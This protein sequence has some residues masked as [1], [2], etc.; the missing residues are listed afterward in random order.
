MKHAPALMAAV[1][2]TLAPLAGRGMAQQPVDL[3]GC[4][5]VWVT[6]PAPPGRSPSRR[7][8]LDFSASKVLDLEFWVV[9]P[10][11]NATSGRSVELKLFT[12]SGHLYQTLAA[13]V[14][15]RP[16]AGRPPRFQTVTLRLP[17]AGTPIVNNSLYGQW[18][19]EAYLGG[20][21]SPCARARKFQIRP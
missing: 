15:A 17:V 14:A 8:P 20:S 18:S 21:T 3:S 6:A 4:T 1:F 11:T 13:S 16:V 10:S 2:L 9:L 19:A 5:L 7:H 12:P